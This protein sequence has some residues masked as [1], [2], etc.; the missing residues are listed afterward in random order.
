MTLRLEVPGTRVLQ[1]H[2]CQKLGVVLYL[3]I[4][5]EIMNNKWVRS[6]YCFN[7]WYIIENYVHYV[8]GV[9]ALLQKH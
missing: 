8:N 4:I 6:G 3:N 9:K 2:G 5:L 7:M 1:S